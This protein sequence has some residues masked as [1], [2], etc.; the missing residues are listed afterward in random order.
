[1]VK[2]TVKLTKCRFYS[3][4]SPTVR[5]GLSTAQIY[6][7]SKTF[8]ARVWSPN[9]KSIHG[10]YTLFRTACVSV[11]RVLPIYYTSDICID[12]YITLT[13]VVLL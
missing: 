7:I 3:G 8:L 11:N 9:A 1:M 10:I 2:V 6:N 5:A 4:Q 12:L 13:P